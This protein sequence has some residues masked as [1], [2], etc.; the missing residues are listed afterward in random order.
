MISQISV[1]EYYIR[2][3]IEKMIK[4][5][6]FSMIESLVLLRVKEEFMNFN[7]LGFTIDLP[8]GYVAVVFNDEVAEITYSLDEIV[9]AT[10]DFD[11]IFESIL[12]YSINE[13]LVKIDN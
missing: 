8:N 1:N 6:R 13:P 7:P 2:S 5:E 9:Q 4:I 3:E 11:M 10:V 12:D